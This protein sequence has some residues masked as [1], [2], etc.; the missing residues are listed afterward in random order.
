[1]KIAKGQY[2]F[3][4]QGIT[5][6]ITKMDDILGDLIWNIQFDDFRLEK[7]VFFNQGEDSLW[8]TKAEAKE[9]AQHFIQQFA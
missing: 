3:E 9:M 7:E 2:Q 4:F 8:A 5:F 1:M 6:F